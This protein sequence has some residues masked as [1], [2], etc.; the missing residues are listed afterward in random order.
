MRP[1]RGL[2]LALFVSSLAAFLA[3]LVWP[4]GRFSGDYSASRDQS[5]ADNAR[6]T[7]RQTPAPDPLE[8]EASRHCMAELTRHDPTVDADRDVS[9][10]DLTPIGITNVPHDPPEPS[11]RYEAACDKSYADAYRPTGKWFTYTSQGFSLLP[12]SREHGLCQAAADRYAL[13]YNR[14]MAARAPDAVRQFCAAQKLDSSGRRAAATEAVFGPMIR[15]NGYVQRAIVDTASG[16]GN[17]TRPGWLLDADLGPVL[18]TES[19]K[20]GKGSECLDGGC[21]ETIGI[22]YLTE[23]GQRMTQK[24]RWPIVF[25]VNRDGWKHSSMSCC[26]PQPRTLHTEL[27]IRESSDRNGC[28]VGRETLIELTPGGPVVRGVIP[29]VVDKTRTMEGDHLIRMGSVKNVVRGQSF[30]VVV[31]QS[32]IVEHYEFRGGRFIG[33]AKSNLTC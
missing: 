21:V 32:D 4:N 5:P 25:H 26:G 29:L 11:T 1:Q 15:R 9:R 33:P 6:A 28:R 8:L 18:V 17:L 22:A 16:G 12:R 19:W 14:R 30:D 27:A 20:A 13:R 2:L 10:G 31:P 3:F 23:N 24:R 7:D